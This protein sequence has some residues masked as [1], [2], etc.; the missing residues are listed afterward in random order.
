MNN[1]RTN[2]SLALTALLVMSLQS[3]AHAEDT[4]VGVA[5]SAVINGS[6]GTGPEVSEALGVA[7]ETMLKADVIAGSKSQSLLPE[8]ARSETCLGNSAC[9]VEAGKALGV[10]QLLM[11]IIIDSAQDIKVEAT[12]VNVASGMTAL[13]PSI[14]A[15]KSLDSMAEL[16]LANA[17]SLLPDIELRPTEKNDIAVPVD[18]NSDGLFTNPTKETGS[19]RRGRHFTPLSTGLAIG[20]GALF[21]ASTV[22][23]VIQYAK[24]DNS[25]TCPEGEESAALTGTGTVLLSLGGAALVATG[26]VYFLSDSGEEAPPVAV[27]VSGESVGFSY[28]GRF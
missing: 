19:T 4:K 27:S 18:D 25:F 7:L 11:L 2:L 8:S 6:P 17:S 9:L 3:F 12:W 21:V 28:G 22:T 14:S 1:R 20:A 10:D 13:R 24:C 16:F 5:V 15:S 26:V 23:G